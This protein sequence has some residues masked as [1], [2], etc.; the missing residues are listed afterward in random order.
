M[1]PTVTDA[2]PLVQKIY[3]RS[4]VGCC[5]HVVLDDG[6]IENDHVQFCLEEAQKK[7][8]AECLE[9]AEM[10]LLMSKTQRRKIYSSYEA[11]L[12]L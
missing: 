2:Y 12:G 9:L 8:H 6:N 10:L 5:L 7:R 3:E 1:K 4:C 11:K